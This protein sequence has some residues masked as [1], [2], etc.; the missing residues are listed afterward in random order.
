M[1]LWWF[2]LELFLT[3]NYFAQDPYFR[4]FMIRNVMAANFFA[5]N[6]LAHGFTFGDFMAK[7][8]LVGD[9]STRIRFSS[10]LDLL[11]VPI[12]QH[13]IAITLT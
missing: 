8:L 9:I 10:F 13:L 1:L 2:T 4:T 5:G 3:R 11:I 7:N 6:F 12:F